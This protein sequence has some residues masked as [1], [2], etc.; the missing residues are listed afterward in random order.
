MAA[1]LRHALTLVA[2]GLMGVIYLPLVPTVW[3]LLIAALKAQRWKQLLCDVQLWQ[4]L[5]ATLVSGGIAV[6]GTTLILLTLVAALWPGA[7]WHRLASRLPW[8]LAIPHVACASAALLLF[9]EGGWLW[10]HWPLLTPGAD[11]YGVGLG[12]VLALKESAFLLWVSYGLLGDPHLRRQH[13]VL[14][15]LG[16]G[17]WQ[18]LWYL[19]LPAMAPGLSIALLATC[20]WSFSVVDVALVLGPGNPP[21]L[22]VLAWQWLNQGDA[23]QQDKGMLA[24]L[25]LVLLPL[26]LAVALHQLWRIWCRRVPDFSGRRRPGLQWTAGKTLAALLPLSGALCLLFLLFQAENSLPGPAS[27]LNSLLLAL[28]ASGC[29]LIVILLWLEWGPRRGHAWVWLPLLLPALPLAAG[30]YRLALA[31]QVDSEWLTVVWG[32]LLWA[33]PWMLFVIQPAWRRLDPRQILIARS[34]GWGQVR[35]FLTIKCPLLLRPLLTALAIGFSV[36]IAQYMPTLWL[37]AGRI[38]TLTTE[39]VALSSAGQPQILASR[40]LWQLMLPVLFFL[41]AALLTRLAGHYRRGL[42]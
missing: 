8:L 1:P 38:T 24:C 39:A 37:G 15:S 14:Q 22:A 32:H 9:A 12:L 4:A 29:A 6:I 20:A 33:I 2:W 23:Q 25:L 11:R 7:S 40:A 10:Q 19:L 17:R 16:Y 5:T 13:L 34:L 42:R 27:I 30:Q 31:F 26:L 3:Q 35:I 28:T 41:L 18:C 21:T 36:S